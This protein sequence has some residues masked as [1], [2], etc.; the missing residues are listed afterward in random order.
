M[1]ME[2]ERD[3]QRAKAAAQ[4][5]GSQDLKMENGQL[6]PTEGSRPSLAI[7]SEITS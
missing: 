3:L 7:Y 4:P 5:E 1:H 6:Q 2:K